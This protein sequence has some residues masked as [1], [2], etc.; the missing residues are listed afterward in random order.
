ML[1]IFGVVLL[2]WAIGSAFAAGA[3]SGMKKPLVVI[4]VGFIVALTT[5]GISYPIALSASQTGAVNGYHQFINGTVVKVPPPLV[6]ECSRDGSCDHTYRC[7]PYTETYYTTS[8]DSKGKITT[9]EHEETEYHH[10]PEMTEELSYTLDVTTDGKSIKTLP[11]ALDIYA[12]NPVKW[13]GDGEVT[14]SV[15]RGAPPQWQHA[16]DS[17]AKGISDPVTLN[18]DYANYILADEETILRASSSDIDT[19]QQKKLLPLPTAGTDLKADDL[20]PTLHANMDADKVSFVGMTPPANQADWQAA[21][22][23]YNTV[24]GMQH[25]GD[26]HVVVIKDST[27]KGVVSPDAYAAAVKAYWLNDLG[28]FALA[29]NGIVL[30]IGVN[31]N[32]T[33]VEWARADTGMP[34]GNGSMLDSLKY[35]L[36]G[37][38]FDPKKVIGTSTVHVANGSPK[39]TYSLG[40][41]VVEQVTLHDFPFARACMNCKDEG[42]PGFVYLQS[43]IPI[44]GGAIAL[45]SIIDSLLVIVVLAVGSFFAYENRMYNDSSSYN[46]ERPYVRY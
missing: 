24:L 30:V 3:F 40:N 29:K 44:S 11:I 13:R 6:V 18:G 23:Q 31:D 34:A 25:Q 19:L 22:M 45:A 37:V 10:C 36:P 4:A 20:S 33:K 5:S 39:V 28:R 9:T 21:L 17:L 46:R 8:T 32:L 2:V 38:P 16:K 42:Q 1:V 14:A 12:A 26:M 35:N 27:L 41:G 7:D 15:P 43:E